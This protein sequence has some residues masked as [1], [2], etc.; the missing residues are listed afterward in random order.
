MKLIT[1][2]AAM[3]AEARDARCSGRH[4][5]LVP[6]MGSLHE[7]HLQLVRRARQE[8]D[9][10]TVSIFVNPTQ[11]APGEDYE[12]YPRD[13]DGDMDRLSEVGGAD[14]VYAPPPLAMYE[15]GSAGLTW[16][17]VDR[18]TEHLCGPHRD[19]HFTG[20]T[21]IVSKLFNACRPDVAVFGLKDAQQFFVLRRMARDLDFGIRLVGVE[22]V[23]ES[24]GLAMSS[25]NRYLSGES[26][27]QAVA[28]SRAVFAARDAILAGQHSAD[29][30][31]A[32]MRV[33]FGDAPLA[34]IE[35]AE[36]VDADYLQPV[37]ELRAGQT[38]VAA[39]AVHLGGARLIDN[40][41]TEVPSWVQ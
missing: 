18:L 26:R 13:L 5:A 21:T 27:E 1:N 37:T 22:T 10:V 31:R 32:L 38:V 34:E 33:P 3:Q 23:R 7:G 30:V 36:L 14:V 2:V 41:I 12:R 29:D 19:G 25:R 16:V 4:L 9:H 40:T 28:L 24:D 35:Y 15:D 39:V 8:A 6:T 11:F 20:V 17:T